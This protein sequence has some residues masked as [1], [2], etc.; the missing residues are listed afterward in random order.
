MSDREGGREGKR[1]GAGVWSGGTMC[2]VAQ[3]TSSLFFCYCMGRGIRTLH[4]LC[5]PIC[6]RM[7]FTK[8]DTAYAVVEGCKRVSSTT[9]SRH[10]G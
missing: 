2:Q 4:S 10:E 3:Q 1:P 5:G 6:I 8:M 7:L 9:G